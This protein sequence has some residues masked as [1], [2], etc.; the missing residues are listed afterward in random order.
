MVQVTTKT[1][2]TYIVEL[3]EDAKVYLTGVLQNYLG[4]NNE[5]DKDRE[6]RAALFNALNPPEVY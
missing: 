1:V 6:I 5:S 2:K 3:D 4:T